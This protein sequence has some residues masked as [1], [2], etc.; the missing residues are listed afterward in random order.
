MWDQAFKK[1]ALTQ[2]L[3]EREVRRRGEG[4]RRGK[5][6]TVIQAAI[7]CSRGRNKRTTFTRDGAQLEGGEK[8]TKKKEGDVQ[9]QQSV[10]ARRA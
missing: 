7:T 5:K 4:R 1:P 3:V 9:G 2:N 8:K 10:M 6:C